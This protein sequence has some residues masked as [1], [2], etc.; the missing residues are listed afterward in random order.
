MLL[1]AEMSVQV[2]L[3]ESEFKYQSMAYL[4]VSALDHGPEQTA[5]ESFSLCNSRP[6]ARGHAPD[7]VEAASNGRFISI[8]VRQNRCCVFGCRNPKSTEKYAKRVEYD[9]AKY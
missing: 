9:C 3:L 8:L 4:L 2:P 6:A 1:G 7:V 5:E